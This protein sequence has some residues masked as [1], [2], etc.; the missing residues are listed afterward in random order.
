MV[1]ISLDRN[2][3]NFVAG[4]S[5]IYFVKLLDD[6]GWNFFPPQ[7]IKFIKQEMVVRQI[8]LFLLVIIAIEFLESD[9]EDAD[10]EPPNKIVGSVFLYFCVLLIPKQTLGFALVEFML[11]VVA[12]VYYYMVSNYED[13]NYYSDL[14]VTVSVFISVVFIGSVFYY[15]KQRKDK[16]EKFS[17]LKFLFGNPEKH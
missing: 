8:F 12:F 11:F 2:S 1:S 9:T 17:Y 3:E 16:G 14:R 5:A 4:L 13:D 6:I 15:F 7:L 10:S